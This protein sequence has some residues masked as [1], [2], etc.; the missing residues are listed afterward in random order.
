MELQIL[1]EEEGG[2]KRAVIDTRAESPM[3][4]QPEKTFRRKEGRERKKSKKKI[5]AP[6]K[7]K[8]NPPSAP[9]LRAFDAGKFVKEF[10]R[11]ARGGGSAHSI[12]PALGRGGQDFS[13][14]CQPL[15]AARDIMG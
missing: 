9:H 14:F 10:T 1:L 8:Q 2:K 12:Y 3:W 11:G 6:C 4:L 15:N 13:P 5:K 7:K